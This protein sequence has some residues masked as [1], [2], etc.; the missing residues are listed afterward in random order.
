[1]LKRNYRNSSSPPFLS[2]SL[3]FP[4]CSMAWRGRRGRR[5]GEGG[6]GRKTN[7]YTSLFASL[8]CSHSIYAKHA[9]SNPAAAVSGGGGGGTGGGSGGGGGRVSS[10]MTEKGEEFQ[11]CYRALGGRSS[12][13]DWSWR[14]G[15]GGRAPSTTTTSSSSS[16]S[17]AHPLLPPRCTGV[18]VSPG[19]KRERKR[20]A[21]EDRARTA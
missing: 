7:C 19:K 4:T 3:L 12:W 6:G 17:P 18:S 1:M 14:E 21:R 11:P 10:G 9:S 5:R 13:Q 8:S 2:L 16:S 15:G 20:Q